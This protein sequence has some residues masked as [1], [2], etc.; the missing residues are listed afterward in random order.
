MTA[1]VTG[2]GKRLG[3]EMALFLARRGHD[4]AVHYASSRD[5]A[6]ATAAEICALGRRAQ[7]FSADLLKEEQVQALIPAVTAALGPLT[8]L[9][10]NASI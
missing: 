9:V 6:E 5:E 2:A 3:R 8:V 7:T 4:V 10:N 1:L